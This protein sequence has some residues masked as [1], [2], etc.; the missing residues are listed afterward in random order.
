MEKVTRVMDL[1]S[2]LAYN[3]QDLTTEELSDLFRRTKTVPLSDTTN[4]HY[5]S[6][7]MKVHEVATM[8]YLVR[9]LT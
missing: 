9:M 8:E 6:L 3:I 4:N 7:Y 2:A 5:L 1:I